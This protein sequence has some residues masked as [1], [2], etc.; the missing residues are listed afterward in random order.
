V[1]CGAEAGLRVSTGSGAIGSI[2]PKWRLTPP[3]GPLTA[4]RP[5]PDLEPAPWVSPATSTASSY[6]AHWI[7]RENLAESAPDVA[8]DYIYE[9]S[10]TIPATAQSFSLGFQYSGDDDV[11]MALTGGTGTGRSVP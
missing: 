3:A 7:H 2:D 8:G 4:Y 6:G 11:T 9:M 1:L 10:F 5:A